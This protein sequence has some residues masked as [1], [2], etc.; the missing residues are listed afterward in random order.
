MRYFFQ[1]HKGLLLLLAATLILAVCIG[2]FA[3]RSEKE[4]AGFAEDAVGGVS[5]VGQT[6]VSG[7]GNWFRN[8]FS[9]FGSVKALRAEN[10]ALKQENVELDKRLRDARGLEA[11][12]AELRAMLDMQKTE[13]QLDLVAASVV[14]KNPSNWYSTFTI[15]RGEKHGIQKGQAVLTA[16]KELVGKISRVGSDWAEVTTLLD[17]ESG[18]GAMVERTKDAGILEGDSSLRFQGKCRL[19]Y[20]PRDCEVEEGDYLETS[21]MGGVFPKGLLLG[22]ILEVKEDT[23]NM[24]R[25]AIVEPSVNFGKLHQ[26]FVLVNAVEVIARE[27]E[28]PEMN[29]EEESAVDT[30]DAEVDTDTGRTSTPAATPKPT[31]KPTATPKP[32]NGSGAKATAKPTE[33]TTVKPSGQELRE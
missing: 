32:T 12:N 1:N 22:R 17:I 23:S 11:E 20:L 16:N 31:A 2:V 18:V 27:T 14:A 33:E 24:S 4:T 13:S 10:E 28:D 19:G 30:D 6:A 25:Y 5:A 29:R 9:G 15:Q 3:A 8:L 7:G 21:G 26:V